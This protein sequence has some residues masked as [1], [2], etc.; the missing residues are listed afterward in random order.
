MERVVIGNANSDEMRGQV[1]H[2]REGLELRDRIAKLRWLG[3]EEEADQ[4]AAD[5]SAR[6]CEMPSAL[7]AN[8]PQTD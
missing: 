3:L 5:L 4:A 1:R 2:C 7:P 8:P 6:D